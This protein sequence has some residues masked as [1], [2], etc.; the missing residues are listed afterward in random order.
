[1]KNPFKSKIYTCKYT[2]LK[3]SPYLGKMVETYYT[4]NE[5][6][7]NMDF[8][9]KFEGEDY[10]V[11][12]LLN[13]LNFYIKNHGELRYKYQIKRHNTLIKVANTIKNWTM[14]DKIYFS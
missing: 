9:F 2:G 4:T 13:D 1:M 12:S 10:T 8:L 7:V 14:D 11:A 3:F 6:V 5:M